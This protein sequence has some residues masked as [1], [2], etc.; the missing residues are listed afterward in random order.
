[1]II[2]KYLIHNTCQKQVVDIVSKLGHSIS[3]YRTCEIEAAQAGIAN[4]YHQSRILLPIPPE[5][6]DD[7][8]LTYFWV[9]N[10]N[11]KIDSKKGGGTD[12]IRSFTRK[13]G[14]GR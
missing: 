3:Y 9:D 4:K 1:M 10:L 8:V 11:K 7:I 12:N 6:P 13:V 14:E 2:P 5:T